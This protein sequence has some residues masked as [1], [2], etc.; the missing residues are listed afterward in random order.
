[1]L[2][3]CSECR[4]YQ[5]E[6]LALNAKIASAMQLD[7]P[8]LQMPE[9]PAIETDNVVALPARSR[10]RTRCCLRSLRP[11]CSPCRFRLR[12]VRACQATTRW[13]KRCWRTWTMSRR[14]YASPTEPVA[15][16]GWHGRCRQSS[17]D[18]IA[19]LGLITYAQL[20]TINGKDVPHLV[21]QGEHGPITILLM[22]EEKVAEATPIDGENIQG[23]IL[24]VGDGSIAI[25]GAREEKLEDVQTEC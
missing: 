24:P 21:I 16:S 15:T 6:M 10:W 20:C 14:R 22:P 9:L 23:V 18:W 4:A 19:V 11:S 5:R 2:P 3:V 25:V 12:S 7:V 1:M 8:E 13:R 17:R